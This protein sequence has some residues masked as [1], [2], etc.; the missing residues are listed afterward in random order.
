M[1]FTVKF[2]DGRTSFH[3]DVRGIHIVDGVWTVQIGARKKVE[4]MTGEIDE[5]VA[6]VTTPQKVRKLAG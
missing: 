6:H 5:I 4:V 2:A 3:K 1:N